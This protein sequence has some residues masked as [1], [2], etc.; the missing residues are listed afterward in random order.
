MAAVIL[1]E[2]MSD[3]VVLE[4]L[5]A[6]LGRDLDGSNV[7]VVSMSGAHAI[8]RHL[9]QLVRSASDTVVGGL[10]DEGEEDI[11]RR[12][13]QRAGLGHPLNR[14]DM[15]SLGFYVCVEDLE[16]ELIRAVGS[17]AVEQAIHAQG[18]LSSFRTFQKQARWRGRTINDQLRRF[19]A[20]SNRKQRYGPLLIE[21]LDLDRVPRPLKGVL[22]SVEGPG[23]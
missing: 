3:K 23:I 1:V 2:G 4:T 17:G 18:E 13:L 21:Q 8:N 15:E 22:D 10:C 19:L 11:F 12:G 16:D 6:R 7:A 20:N 5:A 14:L 9:T